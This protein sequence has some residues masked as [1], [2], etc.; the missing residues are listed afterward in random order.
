MRI[1]QL[2]SFAKPNQQWPRRAAASFYRKQINICCM[3]WYLFNRI[4]Y[5]RQ[6]EDVCGK[7]AG[8][9]WGREAMFSSDD[10]ETSSIDS[11]WSF[12]NWNYV[13]GCL[14]ISSRAIFGQLPPPRPWILNVAAALGL[15][16][17]D[18]TLNCGRSARPSKVSQPNLTRYIPSIRFLDPHPPPINFVHGSDKKFLNLT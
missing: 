2:W 12:Y 4:E 17:V 14:V 16:S 13:V 18:L 7:C 11:R 8:F 1:A 5:S 10:S 6:V 3:L 15:E 9:G